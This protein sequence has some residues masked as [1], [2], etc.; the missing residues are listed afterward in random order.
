MDVVDVTTV[1]RGLR[2]PADQREHRRMVDGPGP[3]WRINAM[4]AF[5]GGREAGGGVIWCARVLVVLLMTG[6][7]AGLQ[8]A[9]RVVAMAR[10]TR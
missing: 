2:V 7:T 9:E 3:D 8:G 10:L 5:A 6:D 1:T 4:A